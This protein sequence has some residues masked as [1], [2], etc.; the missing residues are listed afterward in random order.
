MASNTA[1][2]VYGTAS[3]AT[4]NYGVYGIAQGGATNWAGYFSGNVRIIGTLD[5]T[6]DARLK[7]DIEDLENALDI[8]KQ[9]EPKTYEFRTDEFPQ[10][11]LDKRPQLI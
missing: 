2:G 7:K 10:M 5:N 9:L 8:I 1:T 11:G 4:S 6:S 3:S